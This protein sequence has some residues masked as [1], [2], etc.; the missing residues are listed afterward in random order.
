LPAALPVGLPRTGG[1]NNNWNVLRPLVAAELKNQLNAIGAA[2]ETNPGD[3]DCGV[4]RGSQGIGCVRYSERGH[5]LMA[6]KL[7]IHLQ[8]VVGQLN[9]QDDWA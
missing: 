3:D 4:R 9:E 8:A 1:E 6:E 7:Q 5:P 2:V